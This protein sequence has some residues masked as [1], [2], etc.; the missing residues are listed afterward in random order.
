MGSTWRMSRR[1][2]LATVLTAVVVA[3]SACGGA[4]SDQP[5]VVDARIGQPTGP[6]AALYFTVEGYG[7]DDV[8]TGAT[9]EVASSVQIHETTMADDGTMG[10][11][12]IASLDLPADGELVLE[13]GGY[14]LMLVEAD[15]LDV[16]STVEVTLTWQQAGDQTIEAEVVEP[17]ETMGDMGDMGGSGG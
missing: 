2:S 9:T 1:L 12:E 11:Q 4:G 16:G 10:M 3:A 15:R 13:P 5:R 6:N 17:S 7:Q 8:L 14:H